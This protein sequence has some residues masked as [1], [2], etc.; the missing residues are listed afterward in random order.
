MTSKYVIVLSQQVPA[1]VYDDI[2]DIV[3]G[4][5]I[6]LGDVCQPKIDRELGGKNTVA[7]LRTVQPALLSSN[8]RVLAVAV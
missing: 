5:L 2:L 7:A 6:N 1:W 8:I 3:G 4:D